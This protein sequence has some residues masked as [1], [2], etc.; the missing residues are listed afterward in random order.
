MWLH[1]EV[2][3]LADTSHAAFRT[4]S[5]RIL[6]VMPPGLATTWRHPL[7]PQTQ[8]G[9]FGSASMCPISPALPDAPR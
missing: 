8:S 2:R 3:T 1:A 9:P 5:S 6:I 7:R 4:G